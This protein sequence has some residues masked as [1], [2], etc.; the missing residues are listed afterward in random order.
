MTITAK[1]IEDSISMIDGKRITTM[2]LTYPR[3][4]H[5]EFMTHRMF[6]RNASSSRAIPVAKMIDQVRTNPAMP[7]HWGKNQPGMQAN[8][9]LCERDLNRAKN[10]WM[11]AAQ[12]A[13]D[14]AEQMNALGLHKQVANRILEPFQ[15]IH[16]V[17]TATEF[18]NFFELRCH[19][20]AQPE[21]QALAVE[22]S[23]CMMGSTPNDLSVGEWHLPYVNSYER[24][25]F[26]IVTLRKM[27]AAR[28]ARV[29]YLTHDGNH[30]D[31]VKDLQL[32]DQLITS[33]PMHASPIEHQATP[34]PLVF[35][36]NQNRQSGNFVGW[37]QFRKLIEKEFV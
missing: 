32:Y 29:S 18:D 13:A 5:A 23:D 27:S 31:I 30:P 26:D 7:I 36:P 12:Q 4:I 2:Q 21:I 3:F 24:E 22:M 9:Q 28:C 1:I 10:M 8:E 6:S 20:D 35:N 16:V 19:K 34:M 25:N 37:V 11:D 17:V 15:H 14:I 33:K